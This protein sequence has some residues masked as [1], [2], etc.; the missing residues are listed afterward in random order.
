VKWRQ[1]AVLAGV[2]TVLAFLIA[3]AT[4]ALHGAP[5]SAGRST[6]GAVA[7]I[8]RP[9]Q[10]SAPAPTCA[11]S[12]PLGGLNGWE[13]GGLIAV[14]LLGGV[15]IGWVAR[16]PVR[17]TTVGSSTKGGGSGR[18][19]EPPDPALNPQPLP[20]GLYAPGSSG[21]P[22][23]VLDPALNPQPLPPGMLPPDSPGGPGAAGGGSKEVSSA[24]KAGGGST[25]GQE[26]SSI[27]G[28]SRD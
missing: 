12:G 11:Y 1:A 3:G 10:T 28:E 6:S 21:G 26:T 15:G 8:L 7:A 16:S 20:P 5:A 25:A 4:G 22:T 13:D 9:F 17:L 27:E 2:A 23:G 18:V 19:M 24:R 14:I